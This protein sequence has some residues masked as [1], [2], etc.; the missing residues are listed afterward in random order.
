MLILFLFYCIVESDQAR[1][2][3]DTNAALSQFP[4]H[5]DLANASEC[6]EAVACEELPPASAAAEVV[7]DIQHHSVSVE[8][9]DNTEYDMEVSMNDD[10]ISSTTT[11]KHTDPV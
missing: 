4:A 6:T 7:E 10:T 5:N 2:T 9:N 11:R 1:S 3:R 8:V